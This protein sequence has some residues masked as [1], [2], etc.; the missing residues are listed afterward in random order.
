M[1]CHQNLS[2]AIACQSTNPSF[3]MKTSNK[4]LDTSNVT[5]YELNAQLN[6][7][8]LHNEKYFRRQ[9]GHY[10][11]GHLVSVSLLASLWIGNKQSPQND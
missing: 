4:S 3:N 5:K 6:P 1:S 2:F 10:Y 8:E 7:A 9:R 11:V